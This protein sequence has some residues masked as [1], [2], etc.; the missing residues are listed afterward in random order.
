MVGN[1]NPC[2]ACVCFS[3]QLPGICQ[4]RILPVH[5]YVIPDEVVSPCAHTDNFQSINSAFQCESDCFWKERATY[6][7]LS[8][9]L[10]PSP[11]P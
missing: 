1:S 2:L 11:I 5:L 8:T 6:P 4:V 9:R 3:H 10:L 7:C